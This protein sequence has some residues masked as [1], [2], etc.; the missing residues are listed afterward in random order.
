M[1]SYNELAA[2]ATETVNS[3]LKLLTDEI[4]VL[5]V[6]KGGLTADDFEKRAIRVQT[7]NR[8][9]LQVKGY[10]VSRDVRIE[11]KEIG[12]YTSVVQ[13]IMNSE[14]IS[15]ISSYFDTTKREEIE[16]ELVRKSCGKAKKKAQVM[17]SG[18]GVD[19]GGVFA[20]SDVDFSRFGSN[21]G[22]DYGGGGML[23]GSG[24]SEAPIF[25]PATIKLYAS[26]TVLYRLS[27]DAG[28]AE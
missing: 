12:N 3:T 20:V 10:E 5:G 1:L 13:V 18:V 6:E 15:S 17:S 9:P 4:M 23:G 27:S 24:R 19:L 22:F 2:E 11:L 7:E 28:S 8:E 21:F 26:V 14:N 25:V 16:L